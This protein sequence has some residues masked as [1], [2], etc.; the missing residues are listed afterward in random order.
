MY[1]MNK[2]IAVFDAGLGSYAIVEAIRKA[3]PQQDIIYFADRKNFPYGAKT[4]GQLK[5]IIEKS[6]NFLLERGASFIVLASNAPSITVL[7][8]IK[9]NKVIGIYPPL[10]DVIN[11]KKKN[12]LIIGAKV[13]IESPELQNYIKREV[14][15]SYKQ[16]HVENASSLIQLIESG[17]FINNIE[18]TEKTIKNFIDNCENKFGKLD[19]I[20][21]SS[22]HLPW[23]SSYFK[24]IIPQTKLYDP[25]DSLVKAIKP[26]TSV[27]QGKIHSIISESEKYP[28]KEFLKILD[29]LKIKLDYEII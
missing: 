25:A 7:D 22:T 19:S 17:A 15:D 6:I 4:S 2:P 27:G 26:Y 1:I 11:D 21:L 23:L 24:K 12:T 28:A 14:G 20:T 5:T 13:M 3:Y 9:N 10:R 18:E 8:K 16:F 29:I